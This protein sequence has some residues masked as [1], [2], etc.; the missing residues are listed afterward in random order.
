MVQVILVPNLNIEI[1]CKTVQLGIAEFHILTKY[2]NSSIVLVARL[3]L[4]SSRFEGLHGYGLMRSRDIGCDP[5]Q[6]FV[7]PN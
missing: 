7:Q 6:L 4:C 1:G 3:L 2:S 5:A